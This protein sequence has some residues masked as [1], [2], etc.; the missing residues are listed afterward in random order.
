MN[1]RALE[2]AKQAL[3]DEKDAKEKSF[4]AEQQ[5]VETHYD[6]LTDAL[7]KYSDDVEDRAETL[8]QVQILKDSEKNAEILKNLDTFIT[9]YQAKMSAITSLSSQTASS[10]KDIDLAE[11]NSNKDRWEAANIRGDSAEMARLAGRNA[12]LRSKYGIASD[13]GKLQQFA[14]GGIVKGARG[15]AVPVIAHAGETILNE[16][17]QANLFR[18]LD[19]STPVVNVSS[20]SSSSAIQNITNHYTVAHHG[21]VNMQDGDTA[22]YFNE[23]NNLLKKM[24]SRTGAKIR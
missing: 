4:D 16:K 19:I 1:K 15:E 24:Q 13:T 5:S 23:Q 20:P 10:Q 2:S 8:K 6:A 7:D 12:E 9:Q 14:E 18:M 3:E 22:T 21:D 17:Q 11:Y